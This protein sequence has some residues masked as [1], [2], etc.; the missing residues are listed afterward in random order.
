MPKNEKRTKIR[1]LCRWVKTSIGETY[2]DG[3]GKKEH[4][5]HGCL[6]FLSSYLERGREDMTLF[7]GWGGG[8]SASSYANRVRVFCSVGLL[9]AHV[10]SAFLQLEEFLEFS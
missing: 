3:A 4:V 8:Q 10:N 2:Q 5:M 9:K 1:L 7:L 6:F